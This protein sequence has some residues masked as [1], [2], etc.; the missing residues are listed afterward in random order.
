MNKKINIRQL[1]DIYIVSLKIGTFGF[2]GGY[3]VVNLMEREFVEEKKWIDK[4]KLV[5]ILGIS[6]CL[7]GA[8]ALNASGF[9][10]FS[11]LGIPGAVVAMLGNLT[12]P[13]I[14]V[15]ALSI[16]FQKFSSYTVVQNAFNG[17]RPVIIGLIFYA[18]YKIG[19]AS[20]P[21]KVCVLIAIGAFIGALF[22]GVHPILLI[23]LGAVMGITINYMKVRNINKIRKNL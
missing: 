4:E 14:I 23:I 22:F 6:Q 15:L 2:G 13:I 17:I 7:P 12:S 1:M 19:K 9:L 5:D 3:A 21:D 18:A 11:V 8:I 10:G 16:L 20:L